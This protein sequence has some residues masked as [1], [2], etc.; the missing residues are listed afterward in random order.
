MNLRPGSL[1]R[2]LFAFALLTSALM[3]G[4]CI[5]TEQSDSD[6]DDGKNAAASSAASTGSGGAG[7]SVPM[8][9]DTCWFDELPLRPFNTEGPFGIN[10]H[11]LAGDFTLPLRGGQSW[12]LSTNYTS[13]DSYVFLTNARNNSALDS[14][15]I[16]ARD[17]DQLM[18]R[19]PPNVHYFF[20]AA[21]QVGDATAEIEALNTLMESTF[22]NVDQ[23]TADY[24]RPRM[25]IVSGHASELSG[26]LSSLMSGQGRA[27]FAIDR[28]QQV[29]LMG[30]FADVK[31]YNAQLKAAEEWPWENNMGYAAH[32]VRQYNYEVKRD[33]RL[34]SEEN[35]TIVTAWE[36]E[37]LKF[38]VEKEIEFPDAETM[39]GFDTLEIDLWMDCPDIEGP[40]FGSCGA[41]DYLSH[42]YL[43]D[44]DNPDERIELA[45]FIT[46][47]HREGRYTVDV[48]PM[49]VHLL[50]GGKRTLRFDI[51]P[52]WNQQAYRTKMDFRFSNRGKGYKPRAAPFLFAGGA[53]NDKYNDSF[54]PVDVPISK[55]A[56]RVELWVVTSGHGMK[57]NNCAE[58]CRHQHEFKVGNATYMEDHDTVGNQ[59]GC[60]DEIENGMVPNQGGTW[61]FGRGGW[62]PGQQVEPWIVDVT[63]DVTPG[64]ST[65]VSYKAFLNGAPPPADAGNI[66]M[67]SYLVTYE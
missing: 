7:G 29:R 6:D 9:P 32:E 31:R 11:A 8:G 62:C 37:V 24:W 39:K 12:S 64:A 25:H 10:R 17:L 23:A 63:A 44:A 22:A 61:W 60:I 30:S 55:D 33:A 52:E 46:T 51:S 57:T 15:S 53:F 56:K 50:E 19:S 13:C 34:A 58:F 14:T 47:Y 66:I 40:E 18:Y 35:V 42:L 16:W 3:F 38:W 1:P 49:I 27:G 59:E 54:S 26:Y 43:K 21:R 65:Q 4:A 28:R 48:S 5:V 41:W 45:R 2:S 67:A 36:D 20:V